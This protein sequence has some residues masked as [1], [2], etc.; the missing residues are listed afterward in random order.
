MQRELK[1][2]IHRE[3][4]SSGNGTAFIKQEVPG[5]MYLHEEQADD[6]RARHRDFHR[7]LVQLGSIDKYA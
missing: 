3:L 4:Q 7:L 6:D 1:K 5:M 2:S